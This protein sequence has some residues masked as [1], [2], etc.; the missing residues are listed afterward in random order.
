MAKKITIA[1]L[2]IFFFVFFRWQGYNAPLDRD[3]GEYAYSAWLLR[4]GISPYKNSFLQ[5]PPMIVYTYAL[6]QDINED[7][8]IIPRVFLAFFVL[9]TSIVIAKIAKKEFGE[10]SELLTFALFNS[11]VILPVFNPHSANTEYFML[12]PLV[13]LLYFYVSYKESS[14]PL[15]LLISGVLSCLAFMYKPI[16]VFVIGLI[17]LV[18]YFGVYKKTH[19]FKLVLRNFIFTVVGFLLTALLIFL[20]FILMGTLK[21]L[22]ETAFIYNF[23]YASS[24][25]MTLKNIFIFI[26][27]FLLS[28]WS[29]FIFLIYYYWKHPRGWKFYTS[30]LLVSL[31]SVSMSGLGH[32]YL[33]TIPFFTLIGTI[34]ILTFSNNLIFKKVLGRF[35]LFGISVFVVFSIVLYPLLSRL[36]EPFSVNWKTFG[37]IALMTESQRIGSIVQSMTAKDDK[38]YIAGSESEIYYYSKRLSASRF[39]IIFPLQIATKY[40]DKYIQ[41]AEKEL[42]SEK[43]KLIVYSWDTKNSILKASPS[44]DFYYY[45]SNLLK[46]NYVPIGGYVNE[47]GHWVWRRNINSYQ[48]GEVV[49]AIYVRKK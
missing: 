45:L 2:I 41:D 4:R 26:L 14:S 37:K 25:G 33:L 27:I 8:L 29:L 13:G 9:S 15:I 30:L 12:L 35:S 39:T 47:D 28:F 3:E 49:Y 7:S 40:R 46:S 21:Y 38:I 48:L 11:L 16:C 18:W 32:Y 31:L 43:P 17:Y 23:A 19:S 34:A 44:L 42:D 1:F 6:A 5:K 24:P 22:I 36:F 10:K 20:P